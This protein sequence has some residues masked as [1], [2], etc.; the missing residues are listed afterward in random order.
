MS[1]HRTL[2]DVVIPVYGQVELL[3]RCLAALGTRDDVAIFVVDDASPDRKAV[4]AVCKGENVRYYRN[5]A[6]AGFAATCNRGAN[7]GSAPLILFLNSDCILE[8]NAIDEMCKEMDDPMV[9]AVGPLLTFP[10]DGKMGPG[11]KVQHA[12][13]AFDIKG[14][15]FHVH[16]GWDASHPRV[17]TRKEMNCVT[18]SC[19]LT[20][21]RTFKYI[22]GF[23]EAYGRGTF[24][25]VEYCLN[26]KACKLK[27]VYTPKARAEHYVGSSIIAEGKGFPLRQNFE[28]FK[29]RNQGRILWDEYLYW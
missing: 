23:S 13:M 29:L 9:G 1:L 26:V 21:R 8:W 16:I 3:T 19:M 20:R 22:G 12:G 25:D 27:V 10:M 2:V 28:I 17:A 5:H 18:G 7:K 11:G 24:E 6:N 4:E 14:K 15:P